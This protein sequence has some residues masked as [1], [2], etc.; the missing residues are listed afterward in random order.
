MYIIITFPFSIKG[1][2]TI[3]MN[4]LEI[5]GYHI[6][7]PLIDDIK[8]NELYRIVL[9]SGKSFIIDMHDLASLYNEVG[10]DKFSEDVYLINKW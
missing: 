3:N 1:K 8:E 10:K 7:M 6:T 4:S 9:R 2:K 5:M